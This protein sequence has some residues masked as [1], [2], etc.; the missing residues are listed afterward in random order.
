MWTSHR[1]EN[2]ILVLCHAENDVYKH[3]DIYL[4]VSQTMVMGSQNNSPYKQITSTETLPMF[5]ENANNLHGVP[6][7]KH[8]LDRKIDIFVPKKLENTTKK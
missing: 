2:S 7:R 3:I 8:I 4:Y 6:K 1:K 5:E